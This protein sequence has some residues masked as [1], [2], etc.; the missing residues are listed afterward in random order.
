MELAFA[1]PQTARLFNLLKI[2]PESRLL[3][4]RPR[5]TSPREV[6]ITT[7]AQTAADER[8]RK[9]DELEPDVPELIARPS[10]LEAT[11]APAPA[12]RAAP[13]ATARPAPE[14]RAPPA[15]LAAATPR[16][17]TRELPPTAKS[18]EEWYQ[19]LSRATSPE[20][21]ADAPDAELV[22]PDE[23]DLERAPVA[24]EAG[25]E[26]KREKDERPA[27]TSS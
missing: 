1:R 7:M 11:T 8:K 9:L 3:T 15:F 10:S 27:P 20:A 18:P 21:P 24:C 4:P 26:A 13:A 19:S 17:A 5:R 6:V 22:E 14:Q 16:P 12:A 25:G 23:D 2:R